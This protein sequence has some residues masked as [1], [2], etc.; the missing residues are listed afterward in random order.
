M[1]LDACRLLLRSPPQRPPPPSRRFG[2]LVWELRLVLSLMRKQQGLLLE[3]G[4]ELLSVLLSRRLPE[5][6][7]LQRM[8]VRL[9][10]APA[11]CLGGAAAAPG[12]CWHCNGTQQELRPAAAVRAGE[13]PLWAP[14]NGAPHECVWLHTNRS[15]RPWLP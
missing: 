4:L 14:C 12:V 1:V 9:R 8:A 6:A 15:S 11:M 10:L 2:L 3:L 13:P 5:L 7:L